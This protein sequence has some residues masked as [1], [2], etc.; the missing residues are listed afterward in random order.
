MV[1]RTAVLKH[2]GAAA[3]QTGKPGL[4]ERQQH[5]ALAGALDPRQV[6]DL[7]RGERFDMDVR[8]PL[9]EPADHVG[10]IR[11]PELGMESADDVELAG[12]HTPRL[13]RLG[14]DLFQRPGIRPVLLGHPRERAE[15]AGV[16]RMQTWSG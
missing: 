16:R 10:V 14:E 9:L 11:E 1:A 12:R 4:L 7:D 3:R 13:I 15:H 2:L 8:V 6:R 5:L